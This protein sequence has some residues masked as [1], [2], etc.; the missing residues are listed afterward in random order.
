MP[1][2]SSHAHPSVSSFYSR[3]AGIPACFSFRPANLQPAR[4]PCALPHSGSR[5]PLVTCG[6]PASRHFIKHQPCHNGLDVADRSTLTRACAAISFPQN[7]LA[8]QAGRLPTPHPNPSA[9]MHCG[10]GSRAP[11][12]SCR[13]RREIPTMRHRLGGVVVS[14]R[15]PDALTRPRHQLRFSYRQGYPERMSGRCWPLATRRI[16]KVP[17]NLIRLTPA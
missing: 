13:P 10:S 7:I 15:F 9:G 1:H 17:W 11:R 4:A 8:C 3:Y 5:T 16:E 2:H 12:K 6:F 14:G